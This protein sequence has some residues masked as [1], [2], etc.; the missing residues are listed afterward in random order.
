[1]NAPLLRPVRD[2]IPPLGGIDLSPLF[3]L[4]GLQVL[5]MLVMPLLV[6]HL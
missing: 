2:T 4:L 5:S 3:V 1:M 6:G